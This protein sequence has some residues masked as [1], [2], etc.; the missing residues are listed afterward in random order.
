[1][2]IAGLIASTATAPASTGIAM[3]HPAYKRNFLVNDIALIRLQSPF[4]FGGTL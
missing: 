2:V 4:T 1:M 3:V